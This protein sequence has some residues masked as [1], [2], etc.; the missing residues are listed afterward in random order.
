MILA[1][2]HPTPEGEPSDRSH[3]SPIV[4]TGARDRDA[5]VAGESRIDEREIQIL[6]PP[7]LLDTLD[8]LAGVR[9]VSVGGIGGGSF[10]SVR[11]GDPNFT[12]VTIEGL[13]LNNPTN[14]RGGAFDFT[15]IDPALV[16]RIDVVRGAGSPIHGSDSLSGVVAIQLAAAEPGASF[17]GGRAAAGSEGELGLNLRG[18]AG[19]SGG[20]ILGAAAWYHSGG[21]DVGSRLDR[22]QQLVRVGQR[23]GTFD[24]G[25]VAVRARSERATFP[26]DSGGPRLAVNRER[27]EG[28][29]SLDAGIVTLRR[30]P[31]A[32]VRPNLSF[33]WSEQRDHADTPAIA[34]GALDGVPASESRIRFRRLEGMAD[35]GFARGRHT[36]IIGGAFLREDGR[37]RGSLDLGFPLPTSFEL[38]RLTAAAFAE[39]TLR[40]SNAASLNLAVR[41]DAVTDGPRTW[42]GR[43]AGRVQIAGGAAAFASVGNGYKLP[44]FFALAHPLVGNPDLGT[45]RSVNLEAGLEWNGGD[46]A[47]ARFSLFR[48]RFRDLVDFD[49]VSFRFVNRARVVTSGAEVELRWQPAQRLD[50]FAALTFLDVDS[51]TP[52]RGR[53]RSDASARIAWTPRPRLELGGAMRLNSSFF[54]ASIPTGL[55][56]VKGR[57]EADLTLGYRLTEALRF[58]LAFRNVTDSRHEDAVG[59]RAAPQR[60][61]ASLSFAY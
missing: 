16:S 20:S 14:S 50:L 43:A 46:R 27:E 33:S 59:F 8:R 34:P 48:N 29:L 12:L 10:L 7:T 17:A 23:I 18:G 30:D 21:L 53:P 57:I 49:A 5:P 25:A 4:V 2:I 19:W 1:V 47:G 44:S 15:L 39:A 40:P 51:T 24:L 22:E 31:A 52:L 55:I 28:E 58:D 9:A 56:R 26:E 54:D 6:Q 61:T 32:R 36:A 13:K 11:G 41:M 42:T 35:I 60:A 45:E 37:S 38:T 3:T